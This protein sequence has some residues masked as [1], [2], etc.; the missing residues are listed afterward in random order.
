MVYGKKGVK[1][2]RRE[3]NGIGEVEMVDVKEERK[4]R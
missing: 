4:M 2:K 1:R 3:K